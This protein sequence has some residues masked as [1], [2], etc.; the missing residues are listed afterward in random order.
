MDKQE[1]RTEFL[2]IGGGIAGLRAALGASQYGKVAIL[3]KGLKS[4]SSSEFAQGGIAAALSEE[5]GGVQ[6]HYQD[7]IEAGRGLCCEKAVRVLVEE[8]P[9]RVR[10]LIDWGA[11]FDKAGDRFALAK[12]GAHRKD[13]VLRARGD[14][15]GNEIVKTLLKVIQ[16]TPNISILS[17]RFT[18]DLLIEK[19][20]F[21]QSVC[22]GAWVLDERE[23]K[24]QRFYSDAVV[25]ATGG[26]GQ[27]YHRTTNPSVS[28]GDGIAMALQAG[29]ELEDMEFFQFHPTALCWPSAPS[30]LLSEAMRGEGGRLLDLEGKPFMDR[31]HPDAELAPRDLVSR[32]ILSELDKHQC[33]YLYLDMTHLK[34]DFIRKRFPKIY[35]TCLQY[36]IDITR[37]RIPIAPSAHYLMGG[38]KSDLAGRTNIPGL[39]A[40]GEVAATGVHGANRLASNSLLEGLVFGARVGDAIGPDRST[41]VSYGDPV[42]ALACMASVF[43][44]TP[45][46]YAC[47][48]NELREMMWNKVG[49]IR[50]EHSLLLAINQWHQLKDVLGVPSL[51][52]LALE[53]RNMLWS[54]AAIIES[55]L[56]RCDSIG[57]HFRED[58]LKKKKKENAL[59]HVLLTRAS[60]DCRFQ[61]DPFHTIP[62]S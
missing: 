32:A 48:Q 45:E 8:G 25:L 56:L 39:Y 16:S 4:E 26:C 5:D 13:R 17:G 31:Y 36:G 40:V 14:S 27:V 57:A 9:K 33:K 11:E 2:I 35:A 42:D 30:F 62:R 29:A 10:E 6:S 12:E 20:S 47:V 43:S 44:K 46:E 52:R 15:T 50:S 51:S 54:A 28:T 23:G 22:R 19:G 24:V 21:F 58:A 7:T 55:A 38:I 37:D 49:I 3:N 18:I 41:W 1:I 53:T 60:L 59:D 34:P 61:S